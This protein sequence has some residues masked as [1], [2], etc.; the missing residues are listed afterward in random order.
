M[1]EKEQETERRRERE[2]TIDQAKET[3]E[4]R[5]SKILHTRETVTETKSSKMRG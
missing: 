2:R 1:K 5:C 3:I 4:Y